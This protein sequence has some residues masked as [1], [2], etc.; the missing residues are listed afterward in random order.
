MSNIVLPLLCRETYA[1]SYNTQHNHYVLDYG[2]NDL[3]DDI[4]ESYSHWADRMAHEY[5]QKHSQWQHQNANT[6]RKHNVRHES[7]ERTKKRK[8]LNLEDDAITARRRLIKVKQRYIQLCKLFFDPPNSEAICYN[9]VPWPILDGPSMATSCSGVMM[10][11][12]ED[13]LKDLLLCDIDSHDI[14]GRKKILRD[15]QIQWHPDKFLQR[16]APR[17]QAE[18]KERI[19]ERVNVISQLLNKMSSDL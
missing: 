2:D 6:F 17:L 12:T 13:S 3:E 18:H 5:R 10:P 19:L 4:T 11:I 16:C 9:D 1:D 15:Q 8:K 7:P 14:D